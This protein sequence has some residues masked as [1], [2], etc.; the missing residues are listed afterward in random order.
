MGRS[1]EIIEQAAV[2]NTRS[3]REPVIRLIVPNELV[4]EHDACSAPE[5]LSTVVDGK[6]WSLLPLPPSILPYV[7]LAAALNLDA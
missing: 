7:Y 3:K 1:V 6:M 2:S 5:V 4:H